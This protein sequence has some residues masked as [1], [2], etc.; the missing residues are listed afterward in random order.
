[1][2]IHRKDKTVNNL[3]TKGGEYQVFNVDDKTQA[4][5][6]YIGPYHL[7]GKMAYIGAEPRTGARKLRKVV[8]DR[9]I[10]FHNLKSETAAKKWN[11]LIKNKENIG[12]LFHSTC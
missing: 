2:K 11:H 3:H 6:Y 1:M 7:K 10:K 5:N 4:P 8:K 9:K 12:M